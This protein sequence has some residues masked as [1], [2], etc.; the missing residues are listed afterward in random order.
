MFTRS[1]SRISIRDALTGHHGH[2]QQI[3]QPEDLTSP[4]LRRTD[5]STSLFSL[6]RSVSISRLRPAHRVSSI[7]TAST[8]ADHGDGPVMSEDYIADS[9]SQ[10]SFYQQPRNMT[11]SV[12]SLFSSTSMASRQ[13]PRQENRAPSSR[14]SEQSTDILN[15]RRK[16]ATGVVKRTIEEQHQDLYQ[17]NVYQSTASIMS[18]RTSSDLRQSNMSK[19]GSSISTP[20]SG[21]S[22]S[23]FWKVAEPSVSNIPKPKMK[24]K[25]GKSKKHSSEAKAEESR[26]YI[27]A[28]YGTEDLTSAQVHP[29]DYNE[30]AECR[31]GRELHSS[32]EYQT[33]PKRSHR[34]HGDRDT[35]DSASVKS[36]PAVNTE[37][38]SPSLIARAHIHESVSR[39]VL[40]QQQQ[41]LQSS[42]GICY[43]DEEGSARNVGYLGDIFGEISSGEEE[44]FGVNRFYDS[45]TALPASIPEHIALDESNL[46]T[47]TNSSESH[48]VATR[49]PKTGSHH[50]Y[51]NLRRSDKQCEKN[52]LRPLNI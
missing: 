36:P 30:K 41:S 22:S 19:P 46:Q 24:A 15:R 37:N 9:R 7:S 28:L 31:Y 51:R 3:S 1:H 4:N 47:D 32:H 35:Y 27:M 26:N 21:A 45:A 17:G 50:K 8:V 20:Y 23:S 43:I 29:H 18:G 13:K 49:H 16:L 52:V 42:I 40:A 38:L 5:S 11:T 2:D 48:K 44:D 6:F 39:S 12:T 10:S 14:S 34:S 25:R 33:E